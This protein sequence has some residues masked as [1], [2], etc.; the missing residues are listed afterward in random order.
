V[1]LTRPL[2]R[3]SDMAE[4]A[5]V[6]LADG[7]QAAAQAHSLRRRAH[8]PWPEP[9]RPWLQGQTW[10]DLL[11]AHW[12]VPEDRL[13]ALVPDAISI[14]TFDGHAWIAVT[15]FQVTGVRFRGT[16]PVPILSRFPEVNVRT[17][18]TVQGRP[19]IYFF[20][21]DAASA[22]AVAGARATY[23][24]PYFRSRMA[25]H[26][27]GQEIYYTSRRVGNAASLRLR[28]RPT[29]TPFRHGR[30]RW[31]TSSPNAIA[32]IPS[33][34]AAFTELKF[35]I[36]HGRCRQRRLTSTR[37]RWRRPAASA[38]HRARRCCTSPAARMS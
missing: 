30:E 26:R 38:S 29:G 35:T 24:L 16:L 14:D 13:R 31:S 7:S 34:V 5:V 20:S 15:P 19:G 37:T 32:S 11:F 28:Y 23:H 17:Y 2:Q 6:S 4:T 10:R 33:P 8:R 1:R 22:L 25:V 3:A 18:V 12:S 36:L 9:D 21:L 27:V